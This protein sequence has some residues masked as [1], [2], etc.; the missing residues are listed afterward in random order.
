MGRIHGPD[1][2]HTAFIIA[3]HPNIRIYASYQLIYVIRKTVIIV[4][5]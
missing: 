3:D 4:D 1:L 2:F 5:Q